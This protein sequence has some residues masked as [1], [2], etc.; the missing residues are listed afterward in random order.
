MD[1]LL[2]SVPVAPSENSFNI[3]GEPITRSVNRSTPAPFIYKYPRSVAET[4]CNASKTLVPIGT[5]SSRQI[6][7]P[8]SISV[9]P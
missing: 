7:V 5:G 6:T 9:P 2:Y 1:K 8:T 4:W 3:V